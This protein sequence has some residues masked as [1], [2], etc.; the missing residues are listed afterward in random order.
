MCVRCVVNN[1]LLL[2][3]T[4]FSTFAYLDGAIYNRLVCSFHI[5]VNFNGFFI[6]LPHHANAL[7]H[8]N[9]VCGTSICQKHDDIRLRWHLALFFD[10]FERRNNERHLKSKNGETFNFAT[11]YNASNTAYKFHSD[12]I[13]NGEKKKLDRLLFLLLLLLQ[14]LS[15][16]MH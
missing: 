7:L 11:D 2:Y 9:F 10:G 3:F 16:L 5:R 1:K 6:N 12:S 4:I 15:I 14:S 8:R 13:G